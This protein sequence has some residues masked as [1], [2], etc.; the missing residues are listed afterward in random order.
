MNWKNL[1]LEIGAILACYLVITIP[2]ASAT[3]VN[4]IFN[5]QVMN[6]VE[7]DPSNIVNQE[8]TY[9]KDPRDINWARI[10]VAIILNSASL[11]HTIT[12]VYLYKCKSLSPVGCMQKTPEV[13]DN[14]VDT[15]IAWDDIAQS[16]GTTKYPQE[17]NLLFL[18]KLE[19]PDGFTSWIGIWNTIKRPGR[20]EFL[21]F[22]YELSDLDIYA[23]SQNLVGPIATYIQNFNTIPFRWL[24]KASFEDA[25]SISAI[26]GDDS[27][28]DTSPPTLQTAQPSGNDITV[29]NKENY[30]V[31]PK[32][33]SGIAY[34]ITLEQNPDFQCGDGK[35]ESNLGE[36][37]DTCCF[38]CSCPSGFYCDAPSASPED[39]VCKNEG[40]INLDVVGTPSADVTDCSQSFEVGITAR[41]NNVPASL[42]EKVNAIIKVI[43]TP[44]STQCTK[45]GAGLYDCTFSMRSTV[46]CNEV[47]KQVGP[48]ELKLTVTYNDGINKITRDLTES[49]PTISINYDC[50]CQNDYYCDTGTETCEV[51]DSIT[52]GIIE[53]TD[54]LDSYI[55]GDTIKLKAK[56]NNPPTG[57]V[58]ESTRVNFTLSQSDIFPGTANCAGP[59]ID[60]DGGYVYDCSIQFNIKA[61]DEAKNYKLFPNNLEFDI[62]YNDG[63]DI[64]TKTLS[65]QFGPI[66]IPSQNCGNNVCNADE[67]SN[68]CCQD[69]GCEGANE[70]CD[71]VNGCTNLD[72][73]TLSAVVSPK[74]LEDCKT[75]HEVKVQATVDNAPFGIKLDYTSVAVGGQPVPWRFECTSQIGGVFNCLLEVPPVEGCELPFYTVGPNELSFTIS[76]PE[77]DEEHNSRTLEL[78][79]TFDNILITPIPHIDGVCE[80]GLGENGETACLDCPCEEDAAFGD[81]Y[82][83]DA[84]PATPKGTCLPRNNISLV[85]ESPTSPAWFDTC[86][87]Y[88]TLNVVMHVAN[89]PNDMNAENVFATVGGEAAAYVSCRESRGTYLDS[90]ITFNCSIRI[91]PIDTCTH[92]VTYNYS[93]NSISLIISYDNGDR[94]TVLQTLTAPLPEFFILQSYRSIY[95]ITEDAM[96]QMNMVLDKIMSLTEETMDIV[97]QCIKL[98]IAAFI[99]NIALTIALGVAGG[100]SIPEDAP[101][102]TTWNWE[103]FG[104]G[105]QAGSTIGKSFSDII[106]AICDAMEKMQQIMIKYQEMQI[107]KIKMEM[108]LALMQHA[109]DSGRCKGQEESCF[110]QI[111]SCL[112]HL[113]DMTNLMKDIDGLSDE[114]SKDFAAASGS[115]MKIGEA[116]EEGPW[117][118]DTE[119]A[120]FFFAIQLGERLK[121]NDVICEHNGK[122]QWGD[123]TRCK[124]TAPNGDGYVSVGLSKDDCSR[125]RVV[126]TVNKIAVYKADVG[127]TGVS[128][129]AAKIPNLLG[130]LQKDQLNEIKLWCTDE[131]PIVGVPIEV[132]KYKQRGATLKIARGVP[133][134]EKCTCTYGGSELQG[135]G[136]VPKD[137]EKPIEVSKCNFENEKEYIL[138]Q[139]SALGIFYDIGGGKYFEPH[140]NGKCRVKGRFD[141]QK[142][143]IIETFPGYGPETISGKEYWK[144]S[145]KTPESLVNCGS[146]TVGWL[147]IYD[148]K[149]LVGT[150]SE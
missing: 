5:G 45:S 125:A 135:V 115:I 69:C 130:E 136:K 42:D 132:N 23:K 31:F 107:E 149:C 38:D 146:N 89:Q 1:T 50:I 88:N 119:G 85:V 120:K 28:L 14:Y 113:S 138:F 118:E 27:E 105:I 144:V 104:Q 95:E 78:S 39:G 124:E 52:L 54:Y 73:V 102:G 48:N 68:N 40:L 99:M 41:I 76:F 49:F 46:G 150:I 3:S 92:G 80:E 123:I 47:T 82:Y 143:V 121:D 97:Y 59:T 147:K 16:T 133:D 145:V 37:E 139:E 13:F 75:S 83:C 110:D 17:G 21:F 131:N 18:V 122:E 129:S 61:Y 134:D 72:D 44:Y 127:S 43:N 63:P 26:G 93:D 15:E 140:N 32:T 70:Y 142:D 91:P 141:L 126:L 67:N 62:H 96:N 90:N 36:T 137:K 22:R 33:S 117:S 74:E 8:I 64:A 98:Q 87:E 34:P 24:T 58:L 111:V 106:G 6:T 109:M 11:A 19:D 10:R 148:N 35:C 79:T 53:L 71:V 65:R 114:I 112:G 12:R 108:C 56:I 128:I 2:L 51:E 29:I 86:E 116:I 4:I 57:T 101:E 94:G 77:G 103:G 66:S 84:G 25:I 9:V 60:D 100:K 7:Y 30:F 20:K 81:G 55:P